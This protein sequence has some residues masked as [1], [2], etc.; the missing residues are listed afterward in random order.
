VLKTFKSNLRE[1]YL[2]AGFAAGGAT[3][4]FARVLRDRNGSF[5]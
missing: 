5:Y 3:A 4:N 1:I 2:P